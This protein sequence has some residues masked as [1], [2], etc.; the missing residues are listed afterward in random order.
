MFSLEFANATDRLG[1]RRLRWWHLT[2]VALMPVLLL[3]TVLAATA[4]RH[5][6]A[7][8]IQA[9]VVNLDEAITVNGRLVPLGRQLTS[10]LVNDGVVTWVLADASNAEHGLRDGTYAAVVTIPTTFSKD[11]LSY[12]HGPA[13]LRQ[14]TLTVE[15]SQLAGVNDGDLVRV[16]VDRAISAL[17]QM[18]TQKYLSQVFEGMSTSGEQLKSVADSAK[19]LSDGASQ[20]SDGLDQSVTGV[21]QLHTGIQQL[22]AG[23]QSLSDGVNQYTNG[24]DQA[25]VGAKQLVPGANQLAS[26]ASQLAI[27][28]S[29]YAVGIQQYVDGVSRTQTGATQISQAASQV[30]TGANQLSTGLTSYQD[31]LTGLSDPAKA[32]QLIPCPAQIQAGGPLACKAFYGG[33]S[34]GAQAALAGTR[35]NPQGGPSLQAGASQLETGSSQLAS[36]ASQLASGVD[37]LVAKGPALAAG[38]NDLSSGALQLSSGASQLESGTQQMSHG[39]DQLS[40]GSPQLVQGAAQL[41][42]GTSELN[43]TLPQLVSGQE[44]LVR[45]AKQLKDGLRQFADGFATQAS[46]PDYS[47]SERQAMS[48]AITTP[49][50]MGHTDPLPSNT[51]AWPV[52]VLLGLLWVGAVALYS[53]LR[54]VSTRV[55]RGNRTLIGDV[56]GSLLPGLAI[57]T[58]A[59]IGMTLIAQIF[60]RL[61]GVAFTGLLLTVLLAS[62]AFTLVNHALAALASN[63][64][65]LVALAFVTFTILWSFTT[66]IPT[67]MSLLV[68]LSPVTPAVHAGRA[69][70]AHGTGITQD[71]LALLGW[72]FVSLVGSVIAVIAERRVRRTQTIR[73]PASMPLPAS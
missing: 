66:G 70:V 68:S 57:M 40:A 11:A 72:T 44:E 31:F 43:G 45:G 27:G 13:N 29:Q 3:S 12:A 15:T 17:N 23:A 25:A 33:V 60:V 6:Q 53:L 39:L 20:L 32:A 58:G 64:G 9:A 65:R 56:G 41:A 62:I 51:L 35:T 52:I 30:S 24:V 38:A 49:V 18:L 69:A 47:A 42:Q 19:K 5:H 26:G 55:A 2:L 21:K 16:S 1:S 4:D 34:A 36:G 37:Q 61:S 71:V 67:W 48:Q 59:G 8:R 63:L 7:Q 46:V 73:P 10:N 22:D 14:A 54:P 28:A 50:V